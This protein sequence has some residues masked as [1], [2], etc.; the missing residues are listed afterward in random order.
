[1][2]SCWAGW[3]N[4]HIMGVSSGRE[5]RAGDMTQGLVWVY[6]SQTL[7]SQY[8]RTPDKV[9][10]IQIISIDGTLFTLTTVDHTLTITYTFD[11]ATRQLVTLPPPPVPSPS[12]S[13]LPTQLP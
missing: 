7:E 3:Y 5:G 1:M 13:P 4:G 9:G 8:I 11:L 12:V 10:P 6:D 2:V